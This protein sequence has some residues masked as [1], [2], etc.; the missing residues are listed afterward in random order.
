MIFALGKVKLYSLNTGEVNSG[1]LGRNLIILRIGHTAPVV[2]FIFI[3][4]ALS[5]LF[6]SI[7]VLVNYTVKLICTV[8][9]S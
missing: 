5:L 3:M 4:I 7:N 2:N 8:V 9:K 6:K 1:G